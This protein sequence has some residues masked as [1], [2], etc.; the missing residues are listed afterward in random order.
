[1]SKSGTTASFKYNENGL[2]VQKT[3]NGVT[4][5]YT[6]HGKNI[7]QMKQ[8]SNN[9]H[10]F[11]DAQN[12]PAV[13]VYNGTPYSYVQN[14]QGDIVAILNS[15][16]TAVVRYTY[17]AWGRPISCT[18]TMATTLG[19]FNPFRYRSYV[20]DEETG[21]HYLRSRY[22]RPTWCRFI[23]ADALIKGNLYYY[24][25]NCAIVCTDNDGQETDISLF[26]G[27]ELFMTTILPRILE[28][29]EDPEEWGYHKNSMHKPKYRRDGTRKTEGD[30]ACGHFM[31]A[32]TKSGKMLAAPSRY[33]EARKAGIPYGRLFDKNGQLAVE[34]QV[35]M[36]VYKPSY[37]NENGKR[38]KIENGHVGMLILYDFGDGLEWA[39]VQSAAVDITKYK[40]STEKDSNHG[41]IITS[42]YRIDTEELD[43]EW[44]N[45]TGQRY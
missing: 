13:V 1:M 11:Y 28:F 3:V 39:V 7:V 18:G 8:G 27:D 37:R 17:D 2:R 36:E 41:P 12:R 5:D 38:V 30:I 15:A 25:G 43:T 4:T 22:Y 31:I 6:L 21:L 23:S 26:G 44:V 35:G 14:L 40:A 9:L 16:G 20:Y 34:L 32:I 45:Y 19:K 33:K 10:F 29:I 24:C 42:F